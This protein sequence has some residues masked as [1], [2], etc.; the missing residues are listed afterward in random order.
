MKR[1]P[2]EFGRRGGAS[3]VDALAVLPALDLNAAVRATDHPL[4]VQFAIDKGTF[5]GG[6]VRVTFDPVAG[7]LAVDKGAFRDGPVGEADD[8]MADPP[9]VLEAPAVRLDPLRDRPPAMPFT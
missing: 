4:A 6:P 7:S 8:P 1:L 9:A 3:A 5:R 2:I